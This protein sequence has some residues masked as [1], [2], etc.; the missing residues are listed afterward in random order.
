[1]LSPVRSGV[2]Q[3]KFQILHFPR[4]SD[5]RGTLIEFD[6]ASLPFMPRR[7]FLVRDVPKGQTRGG[8]AHHDCLQVLVCIQGRI[9]VEVRLDSE[10]TEVE[11]SE[12]STG[13]LLGEKVWSQQRYVEENS[14]LLVFASEP[15]DPSSYFQP[16]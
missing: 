5:P 16:A 10:T 8:H 14:A 6:Y 2:F 7:S 9:T 4:V 1:M 3:N 15:F 12:P 11:L 13:L